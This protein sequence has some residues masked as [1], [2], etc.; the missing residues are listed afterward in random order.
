MFLTFVAPYTSYEGCYISNCGCY[1]L[2]EKKELLHLAE[3]DV[4]RLTSEDVDAI[5]NA[6]NMGIAAM[7]SKSFARSHFIK[8][9]PER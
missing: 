2:Q 4:V 1:F 7:T 3:E 6:H 5:I 8:S 9:Y